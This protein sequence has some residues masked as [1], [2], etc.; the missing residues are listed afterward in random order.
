MSHVC[1]ASH[2][3][4]YDCGYCQGRFCSTHPDSTT[5]ECDD[6]GR[7]AGLHIIV[8]PHSVFDAL[9]AIHAIADP[10]WQGEWTGPILFHDRKG[11]SRLILVESAD[12]AAFDTWHKAHPTPTKAVLEEYGRDALVRMCDRPEGLRVMLKPKNMTEFQKIVTGLKIFEEYLSKENPGE[13]A[14]EHDEIFVS[15]VHRDALGGDDLAK[16]EA[17]DWQARRRLEALRVIHAYPRSSSDD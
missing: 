4:V 12:H 5:C 7:H 17:M 11:A 15:G 16:L 3:A 9:K 13:I 10:V 8:E 14:A 6:N 2:L 1:E